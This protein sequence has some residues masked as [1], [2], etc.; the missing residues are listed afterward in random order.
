VKHVVVCQNCNALRK[1]SYI[2]TMPSVTRPRID[3]DEQYRETR[4]VNRQE[5]WM[6]GSHA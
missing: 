4:R 6:A 2:D 5:G 1:Q 3:S